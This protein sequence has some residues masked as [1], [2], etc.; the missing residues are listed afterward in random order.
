MET[1]AEE[2]AAARPSPAG[3]CA[4]RPDRKTLRR[5]HSA[6][7]GVRRAQRAGHCASRT[8]E[9]AGAR[10][11]ATT[12]VRILLEVLDR[13]RPVAQLTA[14]CTPAL[15]CAIGALVAGDHAPGR[16]L[17]SA[18]PG[19]VRLFQV[20]ER[21]AEVVATYQRGPRRLVLAGRIERGST[22][23]WKV[24]ALRIL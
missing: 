3:A 18:V 10:A 9:P 17:G 6:P 22:T 19:N 12:S 23:P 8:S 1:R 24:T 14:L 13:R 5:N 21:A 15:V 20:E 7:A 2:R 4:S 16:T 11:F